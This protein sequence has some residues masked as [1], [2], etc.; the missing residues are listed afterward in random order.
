MSRKKERTAG[1]KCLK[2]CL[3]P[4]EAQVDGC[5]CEKFTFHPEQ[6]PRLVPRHLPLHKGG[7][8]S[9][10]RMLGSSPEG[11]AF[12]RTEERTKFVRLRGRAREAPLHGGR[13]VR[14]KIA[15]LHGGS[16][17]CLAFASKTANANNTLH[18]SV[19]T[20]FFGGKDTFSTMEKHRKFRRNRIKR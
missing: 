13:R 10:S 7:A 16:R 6:S 18:F 14:G 20:A 9:A 1:K 4:H 5:D 8:L 19:K 12:R 15:G 3:C 11:R 17:G 2:I